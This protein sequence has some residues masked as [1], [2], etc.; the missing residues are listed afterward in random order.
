MKN[1]ILNVL[2]CISI[3]LIVI[4]TAVGA[5]VEKNNKSEKREAVAESK[6]VDDD[7]YV[8]NDHTIADFSSV[9]IQEFNKESQ[10]VVSSVD[11]KIAVNLKQTGV[12]DVGFLNKTQKITYNGTGRFYLD[13]SSEDNISI[14]M[15]SDEKTI[16]IGIPHVELMDIEIDPN[17]FESEDA[18]KGLLAF[19]DMKF[20]ANE[21]NEI[22]VECK[23]KLTKAINTKENRL[24]A[25]ENALAEMTKIYDP[26]VKAVDEDYHVEVVFSNEYSEDTVR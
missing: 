20:T 26:I 11:A 8:L 21:F 16:T 15:S 23:S 12:L 24:K 5:K 4:V 18:K 19:G 2:L 1:I 22:E 13:L 25:D 10:F 17:R 9:I 7:V 6:Y 14:A 3:G